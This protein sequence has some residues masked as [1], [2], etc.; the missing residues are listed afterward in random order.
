MND[1]DKINTDLV[2]PEDLMSLRELYPSIRHDFQAKTIFRTETEA[3][4]SVLNEINFPTPHAKYWQCVREQQVHFEQLVY[5]SFDFRKSNVELK[6]LQVKI[7][8]EADPLKR[9]LLQIEIDRKQYDIIICKKVAEERVR[10]IK[11]WDKIKGE[12]VSTG[13]VDTER[14][15]AEGVGQLVSHT[16]RF[17]K[18]YL[19]MG[20]NVPPADR[21]N[22]QGCAFTAVRRCKELGLW[23]EVKRDLNLSD[24]I[25]KHFEAA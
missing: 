20:N 4:V 13:E 6:Q 24:D 11:Q 16:K 22:L 7:K 15:D 14:V 25:I 18:R 12:L 5:L 8:E 21:I 3:R 2:K 9:E 17:V 1:I 23:D 10:E 19:S